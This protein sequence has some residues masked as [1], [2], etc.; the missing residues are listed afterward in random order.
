M[1]CAYSA[2]YIQLNTTRKYLH[3]HICLI[4]LP[5]SRL[6]FGHWLLIFFTM[7]NL[8]IRVYEMDYSEVSKPLHSVVLQPFHMTVF[9]FDPLTFSLIMFLKVLESLLLTTFRKHYLL[10]QSIPQTIQ[11]TFF[12]HPIVYFCLPKV[13][14]LISTISSR[15]I[16][17]LV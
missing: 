9:T 8:I 1:N 11:H 4:R 3:T 2:K 6:I 14:L 12:M 15:S 17:S 10:F 16:F 13:L 5:I 7:Y